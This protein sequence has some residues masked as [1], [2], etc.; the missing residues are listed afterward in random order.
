[1]SLTEYADLAPEERLPAKRKYLRYYL[2]G[3]IDS[4]GCFH[5]SL[6][7]QA[8]ARYGWVLDPVFHVCQHKR[9]EPVLQLMHRELRCGRVVAD[10]DSPELRRFVVD[11]R[12]QIREALLPYLRRHKLIIE[13]NDFA[14]FAEIV[15]AL[16][17]GD[18]KD[19]DK[20]VELVRK[21]FPM[22]MNEEQRGYKL[23]E[24]L[25]D[26]NRRHLRDYTPD[27]RA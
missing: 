7:K 25:M 21:A 10:R 2:L 17:R 20:F 22:I 18:H 19:Y 4:E 27:T 26:L 13:W 9:A 11:N 15:E 23:D 5:V 14:K 24:V 12:Q 8:H 3:V 6:K 1:M 16:E